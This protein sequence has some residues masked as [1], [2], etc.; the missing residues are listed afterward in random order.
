MNKEKLEEQEKQLLLETLKRNYP[1]LFHEENAFI[2]TFRKQISVG[3]KKFTYSIQ[4]HGP[5]PKISFYE[6]KEKKD[7]I[8]VFPVSKRPPEKNLKSNHGRVHLLRNTAPVW[9]ALGLT[10]VLLLAIN[11]LEIKDENSLVQSQIVTEIPD[12]TIETLE[13]DLDQKDEV[14]KDID[15]PTVPV[16]SIQVPVKEMNELDY[17]KRKGT[18]DIFG[19]SIKKY[20]DRYH[21]DYTL[22]VLLFTQERNSNFQ[23]ANYQNV[24]QITSALCG[25]GIKVPVW[26]DQKQVSTDY[27]CVL[28]KCCNGIDISSLKNMDLSCFSNEDRREIKMVLKLYES[29]EPWQFYHFDEVC[30]NSDLSIRVGSAYLQFLI[31]EDDDLIRG[32]FGYNWGR[33]RVKK[34]TPYELLFEGMNGV[35]DK[36]YLENICSYLYPGEIL[37]LKTQINGVDKEYRIEGVLYEKEKTGPSL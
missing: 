35:D 1:D 13:V 27:L 29:N 32:I 26:E 2:D 25:E 4:Y 10:S 11:Q 36:N 18:E 22:M 34:D 15:Q 33:T 28:P 3:S 23:A 12:P 20:A 17:Q 14:Q 24:A 6:I 30:Q 5:E 8:A 21:L 31:S 37:D 19:N 16:I 9:K 7:G